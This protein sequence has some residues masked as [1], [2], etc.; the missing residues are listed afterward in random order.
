MKKVISIILSA[1]MLFGTTA[2]AKIGDKIDVALNTD[3]VAYINNYAI[4]SYAVKGTSCIVAEDLRNFG[5]DVAWDS[6]TRTLSISRNNSTTVNPMSFSKTA[7]TGSYFADILETDISVYA[8]SQKITSYAMNG[9]TMIPVEE[10]TMFGE[11]YWV[12]GERALKLWVNG[13]E[14]RDTMQPISKVPVTYDGFRPFVSAIKRNGEYSHEYECYLYGINIE[15]LGIVVM[16][17]YYP[18][19]DSISMLLSVEKPESEFSVY[20]N[21]CE[22]ETPYVEVEYIDN[23]TTDYFGEPR[24]YQATGWFDGYDNQMAFYQLSFYDSDMDETLKRIANTCL[25]LIDMCAVDDLGVSI[26]SLGINYYE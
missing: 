22:N 10:L 19:D 21:V 26:K 23:T 15:D 20:M 7:K 11:V 5:F 1:V 18:G 14:I 9:Y 8:N 2:F 6:V 4:P 12:E 3:I 25:G 13:L 16:Y 24:N 17:A